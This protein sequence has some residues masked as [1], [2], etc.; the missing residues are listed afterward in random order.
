[1]RA[2][3]LI[4]LIF[5]IVIVGILAATVG[6]RL[7]KDDQ[8]AA[9]SIA[10]DIKYVQKLAILNGSK[11][12]E[13]R[14]QEGANPG[15]TITK[16]G[17]N[18]WG[19]VFGQAPRGKGP[20]LDLSYTLLNADPLMKNRNQGFLR[21][22]WL[23]KNT[24]DLFARD[25]ANKGKVIGYGSDS[26]VTTGANKDKAGDIRLDENRARGLNARTNLAASFGVRKE[27]ISFF[28]A[29]NPGIELDSRQGYWQ[30]F[31]DELGNPLYSRQAGSE[32][33][34][35]FTTQSP[36]VIRIRQG[37]ELSYIIIEG[38]QIRVSKN[39]KEEITILS[40]RG[41]RREEPYKD[42][43]SV[44]T[45]KLEDYKDAQYKREEYLNVHRRQPNKI[46]QVAE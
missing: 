6:P 20:A 40:W 34:E 9:Q 16:P 23:N 27:D 41:D 29:C 22:A 19:I 18:Y 36:C 33:R 15:R 28:E 35:L 42:I 30:I 8:M 37:G 10:S 3:T 2:F 38:P 43:L 17:H 46:K 26:K 21:M 14:A 39:P 45:K 25:Y 1:M 5:V 13:W 32:P 11:K 7:V 24:R 4:E 31:F 12:G 44:S